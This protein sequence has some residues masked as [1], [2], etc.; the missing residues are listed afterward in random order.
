MKFEISAPV[1]TI[2]PYE[3]G[4]PLK[5]LEREYGITH[6]VKLASNENPFGF[7]PKVT[8][9]VGAQLSAMNRYPEP[10]A[11]GLCQK[12]ADRFKVMPENI[13]L[14]N[15]SDD[16]IALLAHGFLNPGDEALMPLPS[17]L[18]YEISVKTAKGVPVMV[19]LEDFTTNLEGLVSAITDKTKMVFITNPFNPTGATLTREE[20]ADFADQ[21]PSD[22]LIV[23]DEAYIEFVRDPMVYNS[24]ENPL[25]DPR[26]VTLRTFSKAYGLAGF[27]I[28]YGVMDPFVA[29]ILN[30]IRQPF[31]VN[32]MAQV[33]AEAAIDD[34]V[35]LEKSIQGTHEGIDFLTR[36]L[37][38]MGFFVLPTQSNFLM[39]D[40]KTNTQAVF[41]KMLGKGVIVRSMASYGFDTFLRVNAG[42]FEENQMFIKALTE[43]IKG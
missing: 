11:H 1:K 22:V 21:V 18:M 3:A 42:T 13:V 33:A 2:K 41:E 8:E 35:F 7:S 20:F 31:N 14:G 5:E 30:R 4:K 24:L 16:I 43:V 6:A 10:V 29:E 36:N 12:L 27:R 15:G 40:L 38:K 26:I 19:D 34:D 9:A 39:V 17:F 28:G 23:V 37:E 32:A 25:A